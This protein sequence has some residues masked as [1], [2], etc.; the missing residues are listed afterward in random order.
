MTRAMRTIIVK[1]RTKVIPYSVIK[2]IIAKTRGRTKALLAFQYATAARAGELA[3]KYRH[4]DWK[5]KWQDGRYVLLNKKKGRLTEGPLIKDFIVRKSGLYW[6]APNFKNSRDIIKRPWVFKKEEKWL[7]DILVKWLRHKKKLKKRHVFGIGERRIRQ[8]VDAELK[9]KDRGYSSHAL[10]HSRA[11]HI[12][13]ISENP[14]TVKSLLG[15]SRLETTEVYMHPNRK[16]I[17]L[18]L[19]GKSFDDILGKEV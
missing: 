18:K 2:E 16:E 4:V 5:Y 14:W 11:T 3:L 19:K 1:K 6:I 9:K 17:M 7:Y 10:R 12:M 13:E 15:H 8:I